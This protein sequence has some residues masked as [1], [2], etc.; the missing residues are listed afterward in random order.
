[1]MPVTCNTRRAS[2]RNRAASLRTIPELEIAEIGE[3]AICCGS[4]GIYNLTEPEP[5]QQL[6][7]RKV[8]HVI[9]THADVLAT[10]NPGC[11]LQIQNGLRRVGV[12]MPAVHPVELLDA[13]I[14][15]VMP[16]ALQQA[17]HAIIPTARSTQ[18]LT[19]STNLNAAS[20]PV[21]STSCYTVREVRLGENAKR[22][23]G[24]QIFFIRADVTRIADNKVVIARAKLQAEPIGRIDRATETAITIGVYRLGCSNGLPF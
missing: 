24:V 4:A 1:M 5:A 20:G 13:S 3:A 15:G 8:Q 19:R 18:A 23:D 14:R 22:R 2:K 6:A 12:E 11:L 17:R 9:Q 7:D 10:S 21:W 16:A